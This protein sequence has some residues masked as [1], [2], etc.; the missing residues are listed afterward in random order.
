M[1][2]SSKLEDGAGSPFAKFMTLTMIGRIS[3]A[4]FSWERK[5]LIQ[6][7]LRFEGRAK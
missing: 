6:A 7:P 2:A 4:S 3:P 1:R 5:A